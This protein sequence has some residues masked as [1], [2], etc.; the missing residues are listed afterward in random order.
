MEYEYANAHP[1][2]D[3]VYLS[4][5]DDDAP[6]RRFD[7]VTNNEIFAGDP[8]NAMCVVGLRVYSNK[9]TSKVSV[10]KGRNSS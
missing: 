4:S 1:R 2:D 8:W 5:D 6:V 10:I 7:L 9:A 3:P